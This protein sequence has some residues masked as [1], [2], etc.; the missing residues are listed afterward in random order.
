MPSRCFRHFERPWFA[1][2]SRTRIIEFG[3]RIEL[4]LLLGES[5]EVADVF[6]ATE[7]DSET[8]AGVC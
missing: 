1:Q 7:S 3:R 2:G 5:D 8:S 6:P 4:E